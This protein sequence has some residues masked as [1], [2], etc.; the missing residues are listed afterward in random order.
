MVVLVRARRK[1]GFSGKNRLF[2]WF[3]GLF[4][5]VLGKSS[6][7]LCVIMGR[8]CENAPLFGGI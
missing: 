5:G 8:I 3:L 1:G 2:C 4:W 6:G 7:L